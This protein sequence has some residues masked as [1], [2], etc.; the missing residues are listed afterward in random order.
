MS[1]PICKGKLPDHIV[2]E[3]KIVCFWLAIKLSTYVVRDPCN[4]LAGF[5]G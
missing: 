2:L 3:S 4:W 5:G 1:N